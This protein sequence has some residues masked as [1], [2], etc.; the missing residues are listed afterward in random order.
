MWEQ[1]LCRHRNR[2]AA[3]RRRARAWQVHVG[4]ACR[5]VNVAI[6]VAEGA[7][8]RIDAVVAEACALGLEHT[9][10]LSGIG[11]LTGSVEVASLP[12]LRALS[13]VEVVELER[14]TRLRESDARG[15]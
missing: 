7:L 11:V 4:R 14:G 15:N 3:A 10:T 8:H 5:R 2:L 6:A 9:S 12:K 1:A 13:D